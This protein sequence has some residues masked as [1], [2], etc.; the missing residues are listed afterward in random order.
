MYDLNHTHPVGPRPHDRQVD[1]RGRQRLLDPGPHERALA[2]AGN[3]QAVIDAYMEQATSGD[4]DHLLAVTM[5]FA[6]VV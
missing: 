6:D 5:Q 3:R 4:Y 2:K 1:R